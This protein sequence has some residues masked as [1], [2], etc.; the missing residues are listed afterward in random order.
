MIRDHWKSLLQTTRVKE[1]ES[2]QGV[3]TRPANAIGIKR[4]NPK[5]IHVEEMVYSS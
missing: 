3:S 1:K 2:D 4:Q 5:I